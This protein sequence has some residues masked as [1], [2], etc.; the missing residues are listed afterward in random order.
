MPGKGLAFSHGVCGAL[1]GFLGSERSN[2][3]VKWPSPALPGW[4]GCPVPARVGEEVPRPRTPGTEMEREA[5]PSGSPTVAIPGV[6][7]VPALPNA[8]GVEMRRRASLPVQAAGG[9]LRGWEPRRE[10]HSSEHKHFHLHSRRGLL[11]LC[12]WS[13]CTHILCHVS[14]VK[15]LL[16]PPTRK[17]WWLYLFI[18]TVY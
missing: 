3:A 4:P 1:W 9:R 17:A 7:G 15:C 2:S 8:D 14:C 5:Q 10:G 18:K 16:F 6:S 11:P 13:P 12:P